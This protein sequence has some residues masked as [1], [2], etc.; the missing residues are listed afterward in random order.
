MAFGYSASFSSDVAFHLSAL[1]AKV[2][3]IAQRAGV[4][5]A[6]RADL[7]TALAALPW[8]E[9]RRLKLILESARVGANSEPALK[10]ATAIVELAADV[11][12]RTPPA[13]HNGNERR[14]NSLGEM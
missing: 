12:A 7:E 14:F 3:E 4:P 5:D 1:T 6:A 10:A 8:P 9:R 11:W 2:D 13:H